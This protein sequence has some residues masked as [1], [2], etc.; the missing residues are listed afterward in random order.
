[1]NYNELKAEAKRSGAEYVNQLLKCWQDELLAMADYTAECAEYDAYIPY[2]EMHADYLSRRIDDLNDLFAG[3]DYFTNGEVFGVCYAT[4]EM[5][6]Y[7]N[8]DTLTDN[9]KGM[10][11]EDAYTVVLQLQEHG[12]WAIIYPLAD[13]EITA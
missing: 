5:K 3:F 8:S 12:D 6:Q 10:T 1:M 11:W 2:D 13:Y 7:G 9:G 4:E